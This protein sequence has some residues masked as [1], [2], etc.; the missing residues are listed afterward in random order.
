MYKIYIPVI[1]GLLGLLCGLVG[2]YG[3]SKYCGTDMETKKTRFFLGTLIT[4]IGTIFITILGTLLG[5]FIA[6]KID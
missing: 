4:L 6:E 5:A 3:M 1:F 2:T